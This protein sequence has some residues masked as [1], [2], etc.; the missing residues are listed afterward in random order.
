MRVLFFFFFLFECCELGGVEG[1]EVF[2]GLIA[3][4]LDPIGVRD[5][6]PSYCEEVC[7]AF[8]EEAESGGGVGNGF[9]LFSFVVCECLIHGEGDGY[10]SDGD[11]WKAGEFARPS[12][13]GA[14]GVVIGKAG[15]GCVSCA[16]VED[17]GSG[18]FESVHPLA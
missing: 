2:P 1:F 18:I 4:D 3:D 10:F 11:D 8:F 6:G 15:V 5:E 17:V 16:D 13:E 7:L 9:L 12:G 14:G